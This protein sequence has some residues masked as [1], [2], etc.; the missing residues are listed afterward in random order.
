MKHHSVE[1]WLPSWL[2][3]QDDASAR[4]HFQKTT[5]INS[6][7]RRKQLEEKLGEERRQKTKLK[8]SVKTNFHS[9][10]AFSILRKT[11]KNVLISISCASLA[12]INT[13]WQKNF[14]SIFGYKNSYKQLSATS[15]CLKTTQKVS[16]CNIAKKLLFEFS[17]QKSST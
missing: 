2:H 15:Q 3:V 16:F 12:K 7:L 17:R 5:K 11:K 14:I 10:K 1:F 13:R 9:S 6:S 8:I 4:P